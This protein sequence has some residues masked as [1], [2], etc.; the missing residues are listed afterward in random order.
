[1]K[2]RKTPPTEVLVGIATTD[3]FSLFISVSGG[4]AS[5]KSTVAFIIEKALREA[6]ALVTVTTEDRWP[7]AYR[8]TLES[9]AEVMV[10]GKQIIIMENRDPH[11]CRQ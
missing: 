2:S 4:T 8:E 6:G 3:L 1:M 5:G 7:E 11:S 10:K 9:R